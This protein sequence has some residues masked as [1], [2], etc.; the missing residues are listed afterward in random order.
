MDGNAKTLEERYLS[1]PVL[2]NQFQ[3][4]KLPEKHKHKKICA[5]TMKA[6]DLKCHATALSTLSACSYMRSQRWSSVFNAVQE[7]ATHLQKYASKM[8]SRK[9]DMQPLVPG[10]TLM[11]SRLFLKVL[12]SLIAISPCVMNWRRMTAFTLYFLMS[13]PHLKTEDGTNISSLYQVC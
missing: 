1:V 6:A 11:K 5:E 2:S 7:F 3:G 8:T 13:M 4:Y 10:P 9:G 12:L